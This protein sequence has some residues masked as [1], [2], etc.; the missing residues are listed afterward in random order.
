MVCIHVLCMY[1]MYVY[2]TYLVVCSNSLYNSHFLHT[3]TVV[4]RGYQTQKKEL[5]MSQFIGHLMFFFWFAFSFLI[6]R[7]R[8]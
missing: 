4:T 5:A 3:Y 7:W 8:R 2:T 6:E 1:T